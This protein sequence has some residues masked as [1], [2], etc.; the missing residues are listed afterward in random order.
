MHIMPDRTREEE[1]CKLVSVALR[2][3]SL[4]CAL[5]LCCACGRLAPSTPEAVFNTYKTLVKGGKLAESREILTG[6]SRAQALRLAGDYHLE[7]SPEEAALMNALDPVTEAV[8]IK[9]A[10][11]MAQ[12]QARTIK[13]GLRL[14]RLSR[15][16]PDDPW[17]VDLTDELRELETF[18][19]GRKAL[20][21]LR[22]QAGDV[23][24][25]VKVFNEQ[26]TKMQDTVVEPLPQ[27]T[28]ENIKPDP[29]KSQKAIVPQ[30]SVKHKSRKKDRRKKNK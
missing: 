29:P 19:K 27:K 23:A 3:L 1:S 13:G 28:P 26:L 9:V 7:Q 10:D 18:L 4:G 5:F 17:K 15:S 6:P 12:V 8:P 14:V 21:D 11:S 22:N 30:K 2:V 16:S 20:E 24:T 25:S